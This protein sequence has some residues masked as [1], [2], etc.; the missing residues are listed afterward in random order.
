MKFIQ[1]IQYVHVCICIGASHWATLDAQSCG[2]HTKVSS[3]A[4]SVPSVESRGNRSFGEPAR[5]SE[6]GSFACVCS[7]TLDGNPVRSVSNEG[8]Q[9]VVSASPSTSVPDPRSARGP[10]AVTCSGTDTASG[11]PAPAPQGTHARNAAR[12]VCVNTCAEHERH[13]CD[14]NARCAPGRS[15]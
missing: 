6:V 13:A 14:A 4:S 2:S 3:M 8:L 1:I 12:A 5:G 15:R 11:A 10:R 7:S 9:Y